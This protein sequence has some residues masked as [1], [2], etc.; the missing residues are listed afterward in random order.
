MPKSYLRNADEML[1]ETDDLCQKAD[2][3]NQVLNTLC[4]KSN[5]KEM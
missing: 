1:F 3:K 2:A 4:Q 5:A